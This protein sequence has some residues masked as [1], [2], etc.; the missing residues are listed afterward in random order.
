MFIKLFGGRVT[1]GAEGRTDY[2]LDIFC[3][4][5]LHGGPML[6]FFAI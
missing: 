3:R 5:S 6:F 2:F 4:S 1:G